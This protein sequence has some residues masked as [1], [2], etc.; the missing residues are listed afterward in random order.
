MAARDEADPATF[1]TVDW[2]DIE[3][4]RLPSG[5]DLLVAGGFLLVGGLFAYDHLFGPTRGDLVNVGVPGGRIRWDPAGFDWLVLLS[6]CIL[7]AV[8]VVPL[9]TDRA[10]ARRYWRGLRRDRFALA[11][12]VFLGVVTA[13][14][15]V[16]PLLFGRPHIDPAVRNNPPLFMTVDAA[17]VGECLGA[18]T[19]PA[20]DPICHGSPRYPLGTDNLGRSMFRRLVMGARVSLL[21]AL[22]A[23]MLMVP[24]AA[25][26]GTVAGYLGGR[27][28]SLLM[29]YVDVQQTVPA[30]LVYLILVYL[31]TRSLFLVVLVFGL[32]SWGGLARMV[33]SAVLQ[34]KQEPYVAAARAAGA[35][36]LAVVRRHLLPNA[37]NTV[38]TAVTIQ[39][40][41]LI[42]AE[43]A[44]A[45]LGIGERYSRSFGQL[46]NVGLT[47]LDFARVPWVATEAAVALALIALAFNLLGDALRDA[48][49]PRGD[50]R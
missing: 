34:R 50:R 21:M 11:A 35:R 22:V 39:I 26:V 12:L 43:A 32:L 7:F 10:L 38:V 29:R 46:M 6:L 33:R 24:V 42:L 30:V 41:T 25:V 15:T 16:G 36:P 3:P 1:E 45:Y 47:E 9:A 18:T 19:G 31:F 44:L 49:D 17:F 27:V 40:P 8:V 28:D 2:D 4:R 48:M 5:H 37:A 20:T 23:S 14:A 13:L